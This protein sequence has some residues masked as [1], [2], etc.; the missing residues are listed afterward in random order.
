MHCESDF[1]ADSALSEVMDRGVRTIQSLI[2]IP[3]PR[4]CNKQL[5]Q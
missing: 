4:A 3:N 2:W 5:K 1:G